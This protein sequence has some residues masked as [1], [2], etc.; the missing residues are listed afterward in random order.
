MEDL[1]T[2][3]MVSFIALC[4]LGILN[5]GASYPRK[6]VAAAFSNKLLQHL[7]I[8]LE[9]VILGSAMQW[10]LVLKF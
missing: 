7:I 3:H 4:T 1:D 10:N 2:A 8:V 9:F 6:K 5:V